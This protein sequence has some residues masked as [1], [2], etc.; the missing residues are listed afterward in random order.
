MKYLFIQ[1][2][3]LVVGVGFFFWDDGPYWDCLDNLS[4]CQTLAW[5]K[6]H[7]YRQGDTISCPVRAIWKRS[8]REHEKGEK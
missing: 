7:R 3:T 4:I 5:C 1:I 8:S 2:L 6:Y